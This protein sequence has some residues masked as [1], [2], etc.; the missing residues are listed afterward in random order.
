M[1]ARISLITPSFQQAAYLEECLASVRDQSFPVLEH[2]VVDGGS[3]DGSK[4]IIERN[5]EG[6]AWW[7]S[8]PDEG[9]SHAINKGLEHATGDVFGWINSDDALL[10]GALE[11]VAQAFD[12]DAQ[13]TVLT[14]VRML[15]EEGKPDRAMALDDSGKAESLYIEPMINQQAT[16]Y[17]MSAV[18]DVGGLE[19]KLHCVMDLE[20][21]WQVLFRSGSAGVRIVPWPLAVFRS[22][23][24][25]KTAT[26]QSL[27][28]DETASVLHGLCMRT[29]SEDLASV[30]ALGHTIVPGLR[31]IPAD[32]AQR[33]LVR[34]MTVH[35]LLKWHH[36]IFSER[37]F[38]MMR[39]L[40][41]PSIALPQLAVEQQQ[42]VAGLDEQLKAGSWLSFRLRRKWKHLVR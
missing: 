7:C 5:A 27:F 13:L 3:T 1:P 30:L 38:L 9:Q 26:L 20:L 24:A 36:T 15:R 21:W 28:L 25:S 34:K 14:G 32:P 17:R 40:R 16:F 10:P 31:A 42:R 41:L 39:A 8:A 4:A 33:D 12:E 2:I 37:D 11:R 35:F 22:H 23:P 18:R 6:L 29:G 19:E